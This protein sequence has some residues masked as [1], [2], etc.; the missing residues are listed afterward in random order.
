MSAR[1]AAIHLSQ[2]KAIHTLKGKAGLDDTLYRGMLGRYGVVTSKDLS[3]DQAGS[4]IDTLKQVAPARP[5]NPRALPMTGR[6]G[7]KI[8]A[9]WIAGWNLGVVR[10]R[11]DEAACAFV[12]RQTGVQRT[13]WLVEP[14]QGRAAIEALKGWLARA[15]KVEWPTGQQAEPAEHK[16]AVLQAQ[17]RCLVGL[18]VVKADDPFSGLHAVIEAEV[19]RDLAIVSDPSLTPAEMDRVSAKL[20]RRIRKAQ[21]IAP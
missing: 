12:E 15:A 6:Y 5:A 3:A 19:G 11:T 18:G 17:W 10:D 1:A 2:L 14:A 8:R 16:I 20:G 4:L 9:L 13:A 7:A 21:G